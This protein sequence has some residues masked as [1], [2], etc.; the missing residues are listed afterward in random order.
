MGSAQAKGV[1]SKSRISWVPPAR[2]WSEP[3]LPHQQHDA[4]STLARDEL[5]ASALN[6]ALGLKKFVSVCYSDGPK[7]MKFGSGSPHLLGCLGNGGGWVWLAV[8]AVGRGAAS[9]AQGWELLARC[10][11]PFWSY[12]CAPEAHR[13]WGAASDQPKLQ[14]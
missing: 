9:E 11:G 2:C 3:A 7:I 10:L 12:R 6:V 14:K 13:V 4:R 1:G 8:G 5:K